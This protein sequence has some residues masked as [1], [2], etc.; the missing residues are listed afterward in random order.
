M[1]VLLVEDNIGL[2]ASLKEILELNGYIV[3]G[4]FDADEA[5]NFLQNSFYDVIIL[6]VMLPDIDGFTLLKLIREK[7]IKTPVIMLTAKDQLRDKVK[8]LELGADD[9]ITKPFEVEE[10]LARIKAVARRSSVEKSDVVKIDDLEVDLSSRKVKKD[11]KEI[12]L[13]PKLFCILEQLV[14]NRGKIVT[15]EMLYGKCWEITEVPSNE[16]L[17]ANIKLLRKLID[18]EKKIIKTI[19]GVGYRID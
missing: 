17:R 2:N 16:T 6:D 15:Y 8:G 10:L 9:Y 4:A 12:D 5:L 7:G 3:D 18:P 19:S 14:R 11:G 13:T 1:K